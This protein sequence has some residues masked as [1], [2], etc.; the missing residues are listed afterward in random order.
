MRRITA[1]LVCVALAALPSIVSS[2]LYARFEPFVD[3]CFD[4]MNWDQ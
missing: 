3:R 1:F 4:T 2:L